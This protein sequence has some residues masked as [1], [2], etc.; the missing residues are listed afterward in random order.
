MVKH[1]KRCWSCGG[2]KLTNKGDYYQ[3]DD[4]GATWNEVREVHQPAMTEDPTNCFGVHVRYGHGMGRPSSAVKAA[5][6]KAQ[7]EKMLP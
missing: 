1:D 7:L 3:C 4:C 2:T 5:A 6:R